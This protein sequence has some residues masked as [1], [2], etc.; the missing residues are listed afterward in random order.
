VQIIAA[1]FNGS[2]VEPSGSLICNVIA[3]GIT[4]FPDMWGSSHVDGAFMNEDA[5]RKRQALGKNGRMI[6]NTIAVPVNKPQNT[7]SG[8]LELFWSR[9][10]VSGAV[11]D[12]EH[13]ILIE[14]HV[15]GPLH[16]GWCS[17]TFQGIAIR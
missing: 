12:V 11:G 16:Q 17:D 5:F 10:R 2:S 4:Q 9:V 13:A 15:D 3:I 1:T 6:K 14:R 8:V 7:M